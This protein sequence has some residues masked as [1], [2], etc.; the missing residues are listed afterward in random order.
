VALL[1]ADF[2][3]PSS[4]GGDPEAQ[5]HLVATLRPTRASRPRPQLVARTMFFDDEV[6]SAIAGRI[7]QVVICGAGYD[8]RALRF[9][10]PGTR[11]FELDHPGTQERKA[12]A[13]EGLDTSGLTLVAAEFGRDDVAAALAAAGQSRAEPTLFICEG[14]LVYLEQPVIVSLLSALAERAAPGSVLAASLATH[15]AGLDSR[16]VAEVANARRTAGESEP[17][18]TILPAGD[19]L[20]LL[21]R[22]GW[23]ATEAIDGA[24]RVPELPPGRTLLVRA[25]L[26]P[27]R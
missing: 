16:Q 4:P 17:W 7:R 15:P 21:G 24:E 1:R 2:D 3:R 9:R 23:E 12:A 11:F 22:G 13:L 5:R 14:L 18:V 26:T 10:T 20:E 27:R 25:G 6:Q 8:D 19:H